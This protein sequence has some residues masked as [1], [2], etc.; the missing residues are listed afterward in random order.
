[1]V[2]IPFIKNRDKCKNIEESQLGNIATSWKCFCND[3]YFREDRYKNH[4]ITVFCEYID[5]SKFAFFDSIMNNIQIE[6]I[7]NM[8]QSELEAPKAGSSMNDSVH[9]NYEKKGNLSKDALYATYYASGMND[10]PTAGNS[11]KIPYGQLKKYFNETGN[12]NNGNGVNTINS[13]DKH[14][15]EYANFVENATTNLV[16]SSRGQRAFSGEFEKAGLPNPNL[17]SVV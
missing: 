9:V 2:N 11:W 4:D 17:D 6:L 10:I 1:M 14:F 8:E 15:V 7:D 3:K 16:I 13:A 5:K 12:G